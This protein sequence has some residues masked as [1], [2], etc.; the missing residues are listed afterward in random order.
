MSDLVAELVPIAVAIALSPFPVIPV[1]L[2][3]LTE[4]ALANGGSFLAGWFGGL[5]GLTAIVA[6]L[7]GVIELWDEAPT[8]AAWA[9]LTLGVALIGFGVR[10]WFAR[11]GGGETPSWMAAL[12]D[13]TPSRSARLGL[14]LAV[15][16]PKSVLLVLAGGLT[17]GSAA[18]G[19]GRS[20]LLVIGF[21]AGAASAV[22]LP[23][24]L[25]L[26][27]GERVVA[28]LERLRTWLIEHNDAIVAVVMV[29]LGV[30]LVRAGWSD[31]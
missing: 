7:A 14:L 13:Y 6:L 24:M 17:I 16:N 30:L 27:L 3:L 23:V 9:R 25:R 11:G 26:A 5:L 15:A 1:V 12:D 28:P 21:A 2:L 18:L 31:L 20:A 10:S 4:R 22:A 29:V 8:W 19:P